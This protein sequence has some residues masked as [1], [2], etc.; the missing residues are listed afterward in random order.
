MMDLTAYI[1]RTMRYKIAII[2]ICAVVIGL[3]I[4]CFPLPIVG[5]AGKSG[6][7]IHDGEI[8]IYRINVDGQRFYWAKTGDNRPVALTK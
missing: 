2:L 4:Y 5:E 3:V 1:S 8:R 7:L 6:V